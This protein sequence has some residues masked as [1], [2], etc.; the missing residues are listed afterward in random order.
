MLLLGRYL[1][2]EIGVSALMLNGSLAPYALLSA[3][4][5]AAALGYALFI[6]V[7]AKSTEHAVVLGGG[8][9][10]LMAALGGIMVPAHVMPETMQ[11]ITW[12][13]PMAWGLKA[14]QALLLNRS[15]LHGIVP[16]LAL[17]AGFAAVSLAAAVVVYQRQLRTQ[18][19]F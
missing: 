11:H 1:L 19:R 14:F 15:G 13:S 4:V 10:I 3:A 8:G 9:I 16:Y 17:L 18:V 2:P 12:V 7:C 5:S 6:S